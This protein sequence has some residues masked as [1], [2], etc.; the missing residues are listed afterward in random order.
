PACTDEQTRRFCDFHRPATGGSIPADYLDDLFG[1]D[2]LKLHRSARGWYWRNEHHARVGDGEDEGNRHSESNRCAPSRYHYSVPA[3]SN[4]SNRTRRFGGSG[5]GVAD[6]GRK[7]AGIYDIADASSG[8]GRD[9]GRW[10]FGRGGPF[11]RYL[12]RK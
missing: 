7:Q 11:L 2:Y 3:G 10:S 12:A 6:C 9:Y 1:D 5:I 8:L 4:R